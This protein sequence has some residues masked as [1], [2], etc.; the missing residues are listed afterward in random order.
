LS[1]TALRLVRPRE[2]GLRGIRVVDAVVTALVLGRS[3]VSVGRRPHRFGTPVGSYSSFRG[4]LR[5][6]ITDHA[7]RALDLQADAGVARGD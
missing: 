4:W 6:N 7:E 5:A 3:G 1:G 2:Y